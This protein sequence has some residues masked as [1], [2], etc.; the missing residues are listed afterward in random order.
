MALTYSAIL[1]IFEDEIS[2]FER[3][4]KHLHSTDVVQFSKS[5]DHYM[6]KVRASMKKIDYNVEVS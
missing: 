6:L 5:D 1:K 4:E 3:G 2:V